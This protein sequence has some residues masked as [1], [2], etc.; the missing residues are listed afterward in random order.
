MSSFIGRPSL[1][2]RTCGRRLLSTS[3]SST[4][5]KDFT[6]DWPTEPLMKFTPDTKPP[7]Q[8]RESHGGPG[9]K[10]ARQTRVPARNLRGRCARTGRS[11]LNVCCAH[12]AV[13]CAAPFPLI[14]CGIWSLG[15][16]HI[17]ITRWGSVPIWVHM[18]SL[19]P[20]VY[21]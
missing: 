13:P 15:G 1:P 19:I 16:R 17:F 8:Q 2:S 4:I 11:T 6:R 9:P 21:L 7:H 10:N 14:H 3:R 12:L 5:A 20:C 18:P